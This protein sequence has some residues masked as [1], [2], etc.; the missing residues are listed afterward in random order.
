[1]R[2]VRDIE[3][4]NKT[5]LVRVDYNLPMDENGNI[6]DDNRIRATLDLIEYLR[7]KRAKIVLASH[8]GRPDGGRDDKFSLLPAALRLSTLLGVQVQFVGD[9]IG[10]GVQDRVNG[11]KPSE[12]LLL[13]NLRFYAEEKKK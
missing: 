10:P 8:L 6:T 4:E 11:L 9:C 7:E 12:I 3:V 1:M 2:S 5:V 13:E